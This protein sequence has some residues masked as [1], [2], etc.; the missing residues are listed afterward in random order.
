MSITQMM[1]IMLK[2]V[3]VK[4]SAVSELVARLFFNKLYYALRLFFKQNCFFNTFSIVF[5]V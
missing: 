4:R 3:A 2:E 1:M 5:L